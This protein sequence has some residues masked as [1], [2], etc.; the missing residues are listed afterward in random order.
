MRRGCN[1]TWLHDFCNMSEHWHVHTT[2]YSTLCSR[3]D[4]SYENTVGICSLRSFMCQMQQRSTTRV[5]FDTR[6]TTK[7]LLT[8]AKKEIPA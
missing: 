3:T 6:Y 1:P 8:C 2:R 5:S 7:M 4:D